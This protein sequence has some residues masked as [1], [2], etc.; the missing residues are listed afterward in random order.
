MKT[1]ARFAYV[2]ARTQARVAALP[3]EEEW[4]RLAG[5]RSLAGFLEEA[6][7]GALRPWIRPFSG[8]SDVHDLEVG[9]RVLYRELVAE[10]AAWMPGP[11]RPA[12]D[13]T[14]WLVLVPLL[15]HLARGNDPPAWS[16]RDHDIAPLLGE[17]GNVDGQ[18]LGTAG[19][20]GLLEPGV[21]PAHAWLVEWRRRWPPC[22]GEF[23]RNLEGLQGL[24]SAHLAAFRASRPDATWG[25]RRALR[26][27]LRLLFH[28]RLLQPAGP[29][30]YLALAALD[31]ERL[32]AE[33]MSRAL[34][35][36]REAA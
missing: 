12:M 21:E 27:R 1:G 6:R 9:L 7:M 24:L 18:R 26:E 28:R 11:W 23:V 4:Q 17:D 29:F 13:W 3:A 10:L 36:A 22:K 34:F 2:Q 33:L 31:L 35:P 32:R 25:L 16:G 19:A 14:R 30:V 5:A 8:Q 20:G 15:D